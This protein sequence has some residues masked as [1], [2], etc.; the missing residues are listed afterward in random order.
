MS[1]YS[2]DL[3]AFYPPTPFFSKFLRV[4]V[5]VRQYL[6]RPSCEKRLDSFTAEQ[7][8]CDKQSINKSLARTRA[9]AVC[10]RST[11]EV[12]VRTC[13]TLYFSLVSCVKVVFPCDLQPQH[14]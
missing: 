5:S 3:H 14:I 10:G 4:G 12:R 8:V 13:N 11:H 9:S 7:W 6:K 1:V 2:A